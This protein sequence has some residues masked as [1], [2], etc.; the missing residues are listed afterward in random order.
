MKK[1][2]RRDLPG[3]SQQ[4]GTSEILKAGNKDKTGKNGNKTKTFKV[5]IEIK[6]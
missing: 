2:K 6:K 3:T 5:E 4:P 1:R